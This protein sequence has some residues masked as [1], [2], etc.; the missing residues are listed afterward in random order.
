[1]CSCIH[2]HVCIFHIHAQKI[3][4]TIDIYC[5]YTC[6]L[7]LQKVEI[8][9]LYQTI[10]ID[11]Q[12][13]HLSLSV[14]IYNKTT[15]HCSSRQ[16]KS[17]IYNTSVGLHYIHV[18]DRSPVAS[19]KV[20]HLLSVPSLQQLHTQQENS[21][22]AVVRCDA[23]ATRRALF[24][25]LVGAIL[26]FS[27]QNNTAHAQK[28]C[29]CRA[30]AHCRHVQLQLSRAVQKSH[31]IEHR[32]R[33]TASSTSGSLGSVP[34]SSCDVQRPV[35]QPRGRHFAI[36]GRQSGQTIPSFYDPRTS[37]FTF[38]SAAIISNWSLATIGHNGPVVLA[39]IQT[40]FHEG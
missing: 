21:A 3:L 6:G 12:S 31:C 22:D 11:L 20:I 24:R 10:Y 28:C 1:M 34:Y 19:H 8:L 36:T 27:A 39:E 26:K 14:C 32:G 7:F 23:A 29:D 5:T 33:A 18:Y 9:C 15:Q 37:L 13:Q 16:M 2:V 25:I 4:L 17:T 40:S 38:P 35:R 30:H